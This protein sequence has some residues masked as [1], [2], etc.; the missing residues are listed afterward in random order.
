MKPTFAPQFKEANCYCEKV[1]WFCGSMVLWF[2][3]MMVLP[4]IS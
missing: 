2:Y 1:V 4:K 3:G